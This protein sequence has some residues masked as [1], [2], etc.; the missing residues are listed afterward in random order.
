MHAGMLFLV[1]G[2]GVGDEIGRDRLR[3][4]DPHGAADEAAQLFDLRGGGP[5]LHHAAP[6]RDEQHLAGRCQPHA[7]RQALEQGGAD[8]LLEFE[9]LPI[10]RRRGDVQ[11]LRGFS[12]GPVAG[13]GVD[14]GVGAWRLKHR[15]GR[16]RFETMTS[17]DDGAPSPR[18]PRGVEWV[19]GGPRSNRAKPTAAGGRARAAD[20]HSQP[21]RANSAAARCLRYPFAH[22]ERD[23]VAREI[24]CVRARSET[25]RDRRRCQNR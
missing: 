16:P 14:I 3:A 22:R 17:V 4:G 13:D 6:D 25:R 10:E 2:D 19:R 5:H 18:S 9:D 7:A 11:V 1:A 12:N 24:R 21:D 23:D 20:D 8:L 15:A